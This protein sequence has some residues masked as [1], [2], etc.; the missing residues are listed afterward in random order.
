MGERDHLLD[1]IEDL[2][3]QAEGI[4]LA[5]RDAEVADR[6][7]AEYARVPLTSRVHASVGHRV[8]V[9]VS[10][11]GVLDGNVERAGRDWFALEVAPA[12]ATWVVRLDAV[13]TAT[14]L[15]ERS[16]VEE[17]RPAVARLGLGSVLR[18]LSEAGE[19]VT[20]HHQ[21]GTRTAGRLARV[22]EDFVE[23]APDVSSVRETWGRVT[24]VTFAGLAAVSA[25]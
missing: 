11:V 20:V 6:V 10:G 22:G 23:L 13:R 7:R 9:C 4:H 17:A 18:R 16:L 19:S 21:D 15:S 12:G 5:D 1:L 3:Q 2:E 8:S 24:L 14:G 25:R